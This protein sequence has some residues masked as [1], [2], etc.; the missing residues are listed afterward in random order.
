MAVDGPS[1]PGGRATGRLPL[2]MVLF[3]G[4]AEGQDCCGRLVGSADRYQYVS[5]EGGH[6]TYD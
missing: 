6:Q 5:L 4:Q 3:V 2:L 1:N